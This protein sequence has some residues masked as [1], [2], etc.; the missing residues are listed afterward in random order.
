[1]LYLGPLAGH[2]R[3]A[4]YPRAGGRGLRTIIQHGAATKPLDHGVDT[5]AA[6]KCAAPDVVGAIVCNEETVPRSRPSAICSGCRSPRTKSTWAA[7]PA[8]HGGPA[9]VHWHN[10]LALANHLK[11]CRRLPTCAGGT[12]PPCS[13]QRLGLFVVLSRDGWV[14]FTARAQAL[15]TGLQLA[16]SFARRPSASL[17]R[18][19]IGEGFV[20]HAEDPD[21]LIADIDQ[22]I[23]LKKV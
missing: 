13:L 7:R 10:G 17:P 21:D 9:A 16:A 8:H 5:H 20:F 14:D 22:A 19:G 11:G 4:G 3:D 2:L 6:T 12:G 15:W 23:H 18:P 1:M